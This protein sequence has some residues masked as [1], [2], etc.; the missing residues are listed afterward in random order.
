MTGLVGLL[1]VQDERSEWHSKLCTLQ[2]NT[3]TVFKNGSYT[4]AEKKM[5]LN[6]K[7]DIKMVDSDCKTSCGKE[8]IISG[9]DTLRIKSDEKS[10][11][12]TWYSVLTGSSVCSSPITI[13][14]FVILKEIGKGQYGKVKL[15]MKKDTSDIFAIKI[16]HKNKLVESQ[17]VDRIITER[18]ALMSVS[19]PFIVQL[20]YA[21]QNERKCYLCLEYVPGGDL[22]QHMRLSGTIPINELRLY[23]AE[24]STALHYLHQNHII[25][26]DLKPENVLLDENGHIKLTD[27]GLS[28]ELTDTE[29][30]GKASSF[31]GTAEYLA[32]EIVMEKPYGPEIDWW[33][34]GILIYEM[35]F[36][37]SPFYS[38]NEKK[39]YDKIKKSN[40]IFPGVVDSNLVSLIK[41]LLKRDV[42]ERF[43]FKEVMSHPLLKDFDIEKLNRKEYTPSFLP[44]GNSSSLDNVH[45]IADTKAL[46]PDSLGADVPKVYRRIRG[47]SFSTDDILLESPLKTESSPD[48]IPID[49]EKTI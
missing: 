14:D 32:P 38:V 27:F 49:D 20:Y 41:G 36:K 44:V 5:S 43:G 19:C 47:F 34:L 45:E 40:I 16:I 18:N 21:F 23:V 25:Y 24:I 12:N 15:A 9:D 6:V 17:A 2:S 7:T 39:I 8:I 37:T 22:F 1:Q 29:M 4:E 28:K 31:C 11:L 48:E 35:V 33:S 13:D 10:T 42:K 46:I 3:L 26:R 30:D